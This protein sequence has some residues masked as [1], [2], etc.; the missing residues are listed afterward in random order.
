MITSPLGLEAIRTVEDQ[1][2]L[3]AGFDPGLG[4]LV[5]SL[6]VAKPAG[7][8]LHIGSGP[9][10][11]VPWIVDGMDLASRLVTILPIREIE[12]AVAAV[13]GD[14]LRISFHRQAVEEFL[15][16][17]RAHRFDVII[18][19]GSPAA[20]DRLPSIR[21]LLSPGGILLVANPRPLPAASPA[22]DR[23]LEQ[24]LNEMTD[25]WVWARCGG[26]QTIIA[27][28]RP[29]RAAPGRRGGRRARRA[30]SSKSG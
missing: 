21:N 12:K 2:G 25:D 26:E 16:D 30:L 9:G 23:D 20:S 14:D 27:T 19:E 13:I 15:D 8:F 22:A 6:V 11:L 7:A 28:R 5:R 24:A 1:I 29:A 17:V 4:A 3:D 18:H 10:G